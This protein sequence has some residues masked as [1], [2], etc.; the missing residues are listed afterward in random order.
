M[1]VGETRVKATENKKFMKMVLQKYIK[2]WKN[3]MAKC[4]GFAAAFGPYVDYWTRVLSELDKP[5]PVTPLELVEGFWPYHDW[6][7]LE[8]EV[9]HPRCL[10]LILHEDVTLDAVVYATWLKIMDTR[11]R[12]IPKKDIECTLANLE[13]ANLVDP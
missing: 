3:G 10:S 7:V 5:I 6:R 2:Y 4:E 1:K 11:S 12:T 13:R 9:S 8:N